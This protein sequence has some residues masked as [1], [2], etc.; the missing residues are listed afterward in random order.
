MISIKP[1][2][3][4]GREVPAERL[5]RYLRQGLPSAPEGPVAPTAWGVERGPDGPGAI[6][7]WSVALRA[8]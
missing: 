4:W 5:A 6:T 3:Y 8:D 2:G 1:A 7:G